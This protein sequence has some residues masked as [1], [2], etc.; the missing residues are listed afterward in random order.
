[1]TFALLLPL[2]VLGSQ[3]ARLAADALPEGGVRMCQIPSSAGWVEAL[4]DA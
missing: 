1:M 2:P 4:L 3:E